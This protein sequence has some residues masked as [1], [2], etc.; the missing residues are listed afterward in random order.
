MMESDIPGTFSRDD[1]VGLSTAVLDSVFVNPA[2]GLPAD[3]GSVDGSAENVHAATVTD[4]P[5]GAGEG[6]YGAAYRTPVGSDS[7]LLG[8][9]LFI[10]VVISVNSASLRRILKNYY[11]ELWSIRIR[12][13]VFDENPSSSLSMA[14]MLALQFIA[15]GGVCA[16]YG[17]VPAKDA[18]GIAAVFCCMAV[19]GVYYIFQCCAYWLLGYAFATPDRRR[20]FVAGFAASQAFAG[21]AFIIPAFLLMEFP[22]WRGGVLVFCAGVYIC[23]RLIFISKGFRIFYRQIGSLLY[24]ILYLCS[25]EII[26]L[27]AVYFCLIRLVEYTY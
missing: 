17:C 21:M 20:Q 7:F 13:N 24:F 22:S 19:V 4:R 9:L 5:S 11:N 16:Y 8:F 2:Y 25:L 15:M 27:F 10:V 18:T 3:S 1:S 6:M 23:S 12:P 26:P 14:A